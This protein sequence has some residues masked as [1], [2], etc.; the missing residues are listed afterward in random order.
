M[1]AAARALR[2][3]GVKAVAVCF[4][5]GFIRPEH[6]KRARRDPAR[7]DARRLHLG[8]PR[9][10]ARVPRVRAAVDGGAERLSR[11]GDGRTTS[12][13]SRPRLAALGMTATPHLTQ[14]NGGV[15]GFATAAD[16]PVRTILSG[17]STGVVGAQAIG[18]AGGL[19]ATSSPSTWAAP[20]P[21]SP[22]CRTAAAKLAARSDGARLSDQG[23]DARHPHRRRRRRLDRLYRQR[24]A[25]EGGA[26]RAG[27][28]PG[29]ACYGR[30]NEE[31]TVT[32]ANVVLQTLTPGICWAAAWRS[33][34][35]AAEQAIARLAA[36]NTELEP[37]KKKKK[38]A[39]PRARSPG[40]AEAEVQRRVPC[41]QVA[42]RYALNSTSGG[43]PG[44]STCTR[45]P[46]ARRF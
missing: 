3:A 32:D 8:R 41:G 33:D 7:G 37:K 39:A 2:A 27:A 24:R 6:E 13:G 23:A 42:H 18:A 19:R 5:Y 29:P 36:N 26:A 10:R 11:A 21:T 30:G 44:R 31:P 20:R 22:C 38:I 9:D 25:A 15:I 46:R 4:L 1:R 45:A 12:A 17:P 14:S 34:A 43:A 35:V 28:D 16:M 40:I